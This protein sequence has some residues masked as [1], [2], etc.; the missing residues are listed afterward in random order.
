[1][2]LHVIYCQLTYI[3]TALSII[4]PFILHFQTYFPYGQY[5]ITYMEK[6]IYKEIKTGYQGHH[7][8]L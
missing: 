6:I 3:A 7:M 4:T 5:F 8:G 1:M 2:H